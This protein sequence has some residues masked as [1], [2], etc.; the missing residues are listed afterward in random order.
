MIGYLVAAGAAL[1]AWW[2]LKA[3]QEEQKPA[4][5]GPALLPA[6][7]TKEGYMAAAIAMNRDMADAERAFDAAV[8]GMQSGQGGK[9]ERALQV[10][11]RFLDVF[12]KHRSVL[13]MAPEADL[14]I[15]GRKMR[16]QMRTAATP[17]QI[18]PAWL[19]MAVN[20][21]KARA[22]GLTP[23]QEKFMLAELEYALA[24]I[25]VFKQVKA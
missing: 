23:E 7:T 8:E 15:F 3:P 25:P 6:A 10:M 16:D 11:Q 20:E 9:S 4:A 13:L 5:K 14:S 1:G 19:A 22:E 21:D 18:N 2:F 17:L 24:S 12:E